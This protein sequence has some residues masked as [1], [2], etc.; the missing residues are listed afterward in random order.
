[1]GGGPLLKR[2]DDLVVDVGKGQ[3]RHGLVDP[4]EKTGPA[5]GKGVADRESVR[6]TPEGV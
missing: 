6:L 2:A 4:R 3:R 5:V 1:M